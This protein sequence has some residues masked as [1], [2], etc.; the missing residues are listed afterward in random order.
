MRQNHSSRTN[1]RDAL[2]NLG[3]D[4]EIC[5]SLEQGISRDD[6][7]NETTA[8]A[9]TNGYRLPNLLKD[10]EVFSCLAQGICGHYPSQ[11]AAAIALTNGTTFSST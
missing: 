11:Q 9:P 2:S 3:K 10:A 4:G 7:S 8:F 5:F 1:N 6:A